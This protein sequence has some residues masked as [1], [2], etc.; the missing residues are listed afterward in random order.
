MAVRQSVFHQVG[1]FNETDLGVAFNDVDFCLKVREAGYRNVWTPF[2]AL[3]H[4][5]SVSRGRDDT[6]EKRARFK[7]ELLYMR[8]KW[9][10][11]I[12]RDPFYSPHLTRKREN[13]A[14]AEPSEEDFRDESA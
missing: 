2:A 5:E 6:P 13:F 3:Y 12:E 8:T 9:G 11:A 14:I 7:K 1:G 4:H 10:A